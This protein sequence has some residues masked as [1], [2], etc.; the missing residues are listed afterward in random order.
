[1]L[2]VKYHIISRVKITQRK[3]KTKR[4]VTCL[5]AIIIKYMQNSGDNYVHLRVRTSFVNNG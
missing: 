2:K 1:M 4:D 3:M 5:K